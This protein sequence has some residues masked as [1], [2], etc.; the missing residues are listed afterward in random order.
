[1]AAKTWTTWS[2]VASGERSS[3]LSVATRR[4]PRAS[5]RWVSTSRSEPNCAK[6]SRSRYWESSSF[7]RPA[8][9]R[10]GAIC[11]LPPTRDTEMPTLMA[12]RTPE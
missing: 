3:W 10:I 2:S 5:V 11:A 12:G 8:T 4:S 9:L 6:A 7:R 1:M